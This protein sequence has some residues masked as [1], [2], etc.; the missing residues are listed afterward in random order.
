MTSYRLE[1]PDEPDEGIRIVCEEH[2][3][4]ETFQRGH[5]KVT[6]YCVG[7]DVELGI[8]LENLEDWRDLQEM[9]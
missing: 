1:T 6:F 7:C 3:E 8:T 9:C 5:R 2:D 4:S